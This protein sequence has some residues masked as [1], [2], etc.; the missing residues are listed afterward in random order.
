M[1]CSDSVLFKCPRCGNEITSNTCNIQIVAVSADRYIPN[2]CECGSGKQPY[3]T[4][5]R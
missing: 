2:L 4:C 1:S 3:N 5:K